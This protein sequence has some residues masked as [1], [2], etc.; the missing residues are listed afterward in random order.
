MGGGE[1]SCACEGGRHAVRHAV[2]APLRL[3]KGDPSCERDTVNRLVTGLT[4]AREGLS[5]PRCN[6]SDACVDN[7]R[8]RCSLLTSTRVPR[9]AVP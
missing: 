6:R 1:Q 5:L 7:I 4:W 8:R 2:I 3:G 9:M